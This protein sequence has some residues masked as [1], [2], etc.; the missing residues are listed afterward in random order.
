MSGYVYVLSN[1]SMPGL[2][3]IGR[4]IHGGQSRARNMYQTGVPAPFVLEFEMLVDC[5]EI[6]E[7]LAHEA[8]QDHRVNESREFF[9]VDVRTAKHT[10][11]DCD[12]REGGS[13]ICSAEERDVIVD[14]EFVASKPGGEWLDVFDSISWLE[15]EDITRAKQRKLRTAQSSRT[16]MR[17]D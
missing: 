15:P 9:S 16:G 12:L 14:L 17:L 5:P 11:I 8:L 4:S 2:L 10:V 6:I 13:S 3:K 1:S 7:A